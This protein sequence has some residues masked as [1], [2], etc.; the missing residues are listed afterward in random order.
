MMS[1]D[2]YYEEIEELEYDSAQLYHE[3]EIKNDY[4]GRCHLNRG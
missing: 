4:F 2:K 3:N 1:K